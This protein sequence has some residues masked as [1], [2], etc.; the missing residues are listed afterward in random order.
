MASNYFAKGLKRSALTVALSLCFAGG[1]QAQSTTGTVSGNVPAGSSVVV[2]NNSGFNRTV[3]ADA[4]GRYNLSN[5]QVGTYTITSGTDTR[6]VVV[7]VGSNNNVSFGGDTTTLGA[8]VV[9]GSNVAQIDVSSV[10]T[11]TVLTSEALARLPMRRNAEAIALLAP[12][13]IQSTATNFGGLISFG[14]AGV[15]E[16][17]YYV[18]GFFTGNPVSNLGGDT[19]PYGVIDQQETYTG[20]YSAKYGRSDGG[21]INQIGKRGTNDWKFGG[22]ITYTPQSLRSLRVDEYYPNLLSLLN[23][24]NA[25]P[26]IPIDASTGLP[27]QYAYES[28]TKPGTLYSR[29]RG[30]ESTTTTYSAYVGGPILKDRLFFFLGAEYSENTS[31]AVPVFGGSQSSHNNRHDPNVYGKLD[32]NINND[33]LLEYTFLG[34]ESHSEG[35]LYVYDFASGTEGARR[36]TVATPNNSF[37]RYNT[38]KYT[39]YLTD[40]L[41]LSAQYGQSDFKN[42]QINPAILAGVPFISSATKQNPAIVGTSPILNRQSDYTAV[43]S[44]STTQGLRVDL[45]WVL[46]NHTLTAGMDNMKFEALSDGTAQV[47]PVFIYGKAVNGAANISTA[48]GVGPTGAAANGYYVR[49]YRY[50]DAYASSLDQKA[51]YLEDR[52]QVTD[53]FLL[54]LGV[55]ND[56]FTNK[57]DA[58][59]TFVDGQNQW[60]PRLGFVWDLMGDSS[61]K[62]FGN[63][64]RYFLSLP[65][66]LARRG[67]S[68]SDF[69]SDYY[70]YTG[71]DADGAPT[72]LTP[73]GGI[74]G[75]PPPGPVSSNGEIGFAPDVKSFAPADLKYIYSDEFILGMETELSK[76]WTVGA[77]L[78]SRSLKSSV[79]DFCDP[80]ALMDAAGLTP[81]DMKDG[82]F[83]AAFGDGRQ[84]QVSYCYMFNPGGTN[85]YSFPNA[86]GTD[87]TGGYT[88]LAISSQELGFEGSIKRVYNA[89]DLYLAHPFDG[90]W[91]GRIDYTFS[92]SRGN[93]EGQVKSEFG[94]ADISK[95]QDWDSPALMRYAYG[96]MA[97]DHR[98]QI[99]MRGSYAIT[100]DLLLGANLRIQDGMPISCMGFFNPDGST[101]ETSLEAD[102]VGYS[103]SYHTCFG[104]VASPGSTRT[105]WTKTLDMGLTYTPSFLDKKMSIGL[106]VFNVFNEQKAQQFDIQSEVRQGPYV[107]NNT[108]LMPSGNGRRQTPRSMMLTVSYDY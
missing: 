58:G 106:Q 9:T 14:G 17:A 75:K 21:V 60:A 104:K 48:L 13:A 18:N 86:N 15:S 71:V 67:A 52:W 44:H 93:T 22:Q 16:N 20:G 50:T 63:A 92:K 101:D 29:G 105:P 41:T 5:L 28:A 27:Y 42:D 47:A 64:G 77:K 3:T 1:V 78:T 88:D 23:E 108:F 45:E 76:S 84:V 59:T 54:S 66:S 99:K 46:G 65:N 79:D 36:P 37:T 43:D 30:N 96:Y 2:T 87:L 100:S 107:V 94:Q 55:R 33:H 39:G 61:F 25:N 19:L 26:N 35:D 11:R 32:W 34:S 85:T 70:T 8:V 4:N 98:H 97:N 51:Y 74:N 6:N 90:K 91:E 31:R 62:V 81:Y 12:G 83:L 38:L 69:S 95:T 57:N 24:A 7:T 68:A 82:K 56:S 73:I 10:D 72:G 40:T 89:L 103:S 49:K 80:Y 102:P 53:N